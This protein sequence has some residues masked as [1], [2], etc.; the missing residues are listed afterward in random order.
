MF[1]SCLAGLALACSAAAPIQFENGPDGFSEGLARFQRDGQF[2]F[3]DRTGR[4]TISPR[5][6]WVEPFPKG[7]ARYGSGCEFVPDGEH[8]RVE[9]TTWGRVDRNGRPVSP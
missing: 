8:R 4:V 2:G 5:F 7:H 6:E 1:L 3:F 9:C